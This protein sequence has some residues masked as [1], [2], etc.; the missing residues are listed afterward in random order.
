MQVCMAN[1][2]AMKEAHLTFHLGYDGL[3]TSTV[4]QN[5]KHIYEHAKL[6]SLTT[7]LK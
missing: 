5:I 6:S 3:P 7:S 4:G 1:I 2:S